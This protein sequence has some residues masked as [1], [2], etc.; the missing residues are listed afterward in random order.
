[1]P[2][3]VIFTFYAL[4]LFFFPLSTAGAGIS[5]GLFLFMYAVSGHWKR[6]REITKRSWALPLALLIS[7]SFLGLLWTN[8]LHAGFKIAVATGYGIYAFMGATLPWRNLWVRWLIRLF[9]AG[10][11]LNAVAAFLMTWHVLPWH[12]EDYIA[13]TGFADHIW[14]SMALTHALLWIL[15]DL[16]AKWNF[17]LW[18]NLI[19]GALFFI[20]LAITPGRSGQLLFVLLMPVSV[21]I[22]FNGKWRYWAFGVITLGIAGMALSPIVQSRVALGAQNLEQFIA[23]PDTTTTSWGE[24]LATMWA[25]IDM[26]YEHPIAGVGTGGFASAMA[27]LQKR[28]LIT[29]TPGTV[30]DSAANSYISEA[31]VLGIPGLL[32]LLW[33]L[34]ALT[35][36][37]W[38]VYMTPQG[39]FVLSYLGIF[40]IGSLYNTLTWGYADALTIAILAGLPLTISKTH[41]AKAMEI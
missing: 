23:N 31:A 29:E 40:W 27:D 10:L 21:W 22:L 17:G 33:F 19:I 9:L 15:W 20:Q 3:S 16:R 38:N 37:V 28:H 14:L 12:N 35:K 30:G 25:G 34:I 5:A 1:M 7:L 8:D 36:E 41:Y 2:D 18:T 32:L 39:W 6:W 13:Y 11:F 26:A 24:R 4:P